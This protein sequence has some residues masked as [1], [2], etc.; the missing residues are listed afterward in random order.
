MTDAKDP[1]PFLR[2]ATEEA[3][4]PPDLIERYKAMI[5]D[6]SSFD[7]GFESLMGYFLF[8]DSPRTNAIVERLQ[9]VG[10]RRLADM[11]AT[12]IDRQIVSLTAPGL[13]A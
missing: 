11:D 4:A 8:N 2:I 1:R 10:E 5:K 9:D 3:Y 7:P 6:H 12:G 13:Q